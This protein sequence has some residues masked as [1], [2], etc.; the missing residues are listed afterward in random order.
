[1]TSEPGEVFSPGSLLVASGATWRVDRARPFKDGWLVKF[2]GIDDKTAADKCRGI[3]LSADEA[4]LAPPDENEVYLDELAGMLVRDEPHGEIGVVASWYELPQGIV[5]EVRGEK[6]K[7][8]IPFNEAFVVAVD[9]EAR[10]ISVKLPD[11]LLESSEA[12][13]RERRA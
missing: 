9:R 8:D 12:S 6:W 4:T 13:R 3:E 5:L 10:S 11:G 7:A 2:D 1:V